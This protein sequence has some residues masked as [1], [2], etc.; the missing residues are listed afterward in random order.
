MKPE[1][2]RHGRDEKLLEKLSDSLINLVLIFIGM[3]VFLYVNKINFA[4][5]SRNIKSFLNNK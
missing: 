5:V 4:K 1:Y 3:Q 2:K